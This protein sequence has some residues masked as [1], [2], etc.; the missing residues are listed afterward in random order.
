VT[1]RSAY[2]PRVADLDRLTAADFL[3]LLHER[4]RL[5]AG[6]PFDVELVDVSQPGTAGAAREQFSLTFEGGPPS[7]LP[8]R[9]YPIEHERLGRLELFLVPVAPQRYQAVFA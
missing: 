9:I 4:F 8:Q 5:D 7:P 1:G 6:E 2:D 3:P